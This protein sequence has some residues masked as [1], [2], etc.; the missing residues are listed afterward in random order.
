MSERIKQCGFTCIRITY[1]GDGQKLAF[2]PVGAVQGALRAHTLDPILQFSNPPADPAAIRFKFLFAGAACPDASAE[3]R[4]KHAVTG[5]ARKEI[6]QLGQLDLQLSF[7]ASRPPGENIENQLGTV[8]HF[9]VEYFFE[10]AKLGGGQIIVKDHQIGPRA[11]GQAANL[12]GLPASY[13]GCRIRL[14]GS[15][16]YRT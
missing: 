8:D 7:A 9:Q 1:Q 5:E 16:Q 11:M 12:L 14:V 10:V 15:L 2:V 13:Q 3:S 6:I 4:E